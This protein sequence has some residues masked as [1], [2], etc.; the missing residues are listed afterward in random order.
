[1]ENNPFIVRGRHSKLSKKLTKIKS[2]KSPYEDQ[3][4][5]PTAYVAPEKPAHPK[6]E[7]KVYTTRIVHHTNVDRVVR[8][9]HMLEKKGAP[10]CIPQLRDTN[11]R[12][13]HARSGQNYYQFSDHD[14]VQV[15]NYM[16]DMI[17]WLIL[18]G[19]VLGSDK[20]HVEKKRHHVDADY[21]VN[22]F[23]LSCNG[24]INSVKIDQRVQV[25]S[26]VPLLGDILKFE[27]SE[28]DMEVGANSDMDLQPATT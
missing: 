7:H 23:V 20:D 5:R 9:L 28:P 26:A 2:V 18:S 4:D 3:K 24:F 14:M 25:F 19:S 22:M 8:Y 15:V 17:G 12:G 27:N 6:V 21:L 1:M 10:K 16:I 13:L 11:L